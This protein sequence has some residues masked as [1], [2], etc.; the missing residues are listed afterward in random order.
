MAVAL[1]KIVAAAGEDAILGALSVAGKKPLALTTIVGQLVLLD[2]AEVCLPGSVHHFYQMLLRE[3]AQLVLG[4]DEMVAGIDVA[5]PL[6]DTG[7]ATTLGERAYSRCHSCPVGESGV[8]QL[9][10]SFTNIFLDPFVKQLASEFPPLF[11]SDGKLG[12]VVGFTLIN[13]S[14]IATVVML[15]QAFY[16]GG[17]LYKPATNAF[18]EMVEFQRMVGIEVIDDGQSIPFHAMFVEEVDALHYPVKGVCTATHLAVGIMVLPR[19]IDRD[20]HKPSVV[21][22]KLAPLVV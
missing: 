9:D 10:E 2:V 1:A 6:H 8:K 3:V 21:M 22:E 19:A 17:E 20:A 11:G 5:V 15:E 16:N 13:G 18:E 7:M 14:K 4:E 12:Q